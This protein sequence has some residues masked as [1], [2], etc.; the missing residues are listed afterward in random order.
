MCSFTGRNEKSVSEEN[1]FRPKLMRIKM[2]LLDNY[3]NVL[4]KELEKSERII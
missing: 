3:G 2:T 1:S 4:D